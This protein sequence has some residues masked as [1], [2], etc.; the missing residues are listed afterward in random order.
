M[1]IAAGDIDVAVD[2]R[3]SLQEQLRGVRMLLWHLE[4]EEDLPVIVHVPDIRLLAKDNMDDDISID[5][6]TRRL[7]NL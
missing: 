5:E 2:Q 1:A 6:Y 3:S 4:Y 7:P